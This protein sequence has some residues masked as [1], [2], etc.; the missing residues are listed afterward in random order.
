MADQLCPACFSVV[1]IQV[2]EYPDLSDPGGGVRHVRAW[3]VKPG[4]NWRDQGIVH[5]PGEWT[6]MLRR[7]R[8]PDRK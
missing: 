6:L 1:C 2:S 8:P 3:C 5:V 7:R 4:C